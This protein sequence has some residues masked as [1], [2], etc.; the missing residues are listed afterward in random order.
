[1]FRLGS[2]RIFPGT[3]RLHEEACLLSVLFWCIDDSKL[4][5]IISIVVNGLG[6]GSTLKDTVC[7]RLFVLV[8]EPLLVLRR[9]FGMIADWVASDELASFLVTREGFPLRDFA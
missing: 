1:M 6:N 9:L 8:E 3:S 7:S 5:I 2:P 4:L